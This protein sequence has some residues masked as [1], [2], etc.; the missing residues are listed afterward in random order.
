MTITKLLNRASKWT[1]GAYARDKEGLI[2]LA[3]GKNAVC[4]CAA[5]AVFKCY[6]LG[7]RNAIFI[8]IAEALGKNPA[9][10][11]AFTVVTEFNDDPKTTFKQLRAV[12]RR[13]SKIL[14]REV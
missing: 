12:I 6:R 4:W 9:E 14:G 10:H 1:K 11:D 3:R 2:E 8:K 13:A 5:G 7:R